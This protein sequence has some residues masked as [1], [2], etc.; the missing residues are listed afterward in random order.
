MSTK[1]ASSTL[2]PAKPDAGR[3]TEASAANPAANP[4]VCLARLRALPRTDFLRREEH[5][6]LLGVGGV[7]MSA[8]FESLLARGFEVSGSEQQPTDAFQRLQKRGLAVYLGHRPEFLQRAQVI[9]YS[10][11]LTPTHPLWV[12]LWKRRLPCWQR[13]EA[14]AAL[15]AEAAQTCAIAGTH[16]KTTTTAALAWT[17]QK[18]GR[19]PHAW[20]GGQVPP[21]NNGYLHGNDALAIVEADESDGSLLALNPQ[22]VLLT[23]IG[24]DHLDQHGSMAALERVFERFLDRLP[25]G[26]GRLVYCCDDHRATQ[27]AARW[28]TKRKKARLCSYGF[29]PSAEIRVLPR[30]HVD[31][32][33]PF[34]LLDRYTPAAEK[35]P[36]EGNLRGEKAQEDNN[37]QEGTLFPLRTPL[38]GAHN[39]ANLA[40]VYAM[41]RTFGVEREDILAALAT[42][43]GVERRQQYLGRPPHLPHLRLYDDY[44]HHPLALQVTLAAFAAAFPKEPLT[45]VFQPH[46]YSRTQ[47]FANA[48]ARALRPAK[49]VILTEI[50][51]SREQP[52]AGVNAKLI[53]NALR[54]RGHPD[55]ID[56][57]HWRCLL[58]EDERY[59]PKKGLLITMGAGDI[60]DFGPAWLAKHRAR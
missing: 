48:F 8:L 14:L 53:V 6:H 4:T 7:G 41:A 10:S 49:R 2:N 59:L 23:N 33:T 5:H 31:L 28:H 15:C 60:A 38:F 58:E 55:V 24:D 3:F 43:Q 34:T 37:P 57:P 46:L 52:I 47:R 17:M 56:L 32:G 21:W 51:A 54:Q 1:P 26:E 27:A 25:R 13:A 36:Q 29:H 45:V 19:Q 12:T 50:Y 16:G 9:I 42:F 22:A 39:A 35:H 30:S 40:G 44:A 20:I 11:A 18:A